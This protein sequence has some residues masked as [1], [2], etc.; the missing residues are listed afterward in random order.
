V[1]YSS[2]LYLLSGSLGATALRE[3]IVLIPAR[4]LA[5]SDQAF[6]LVRRRFA[7]SQVRQHLVLGI[8]A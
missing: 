1:V 3:P 4:P 6:Y 5:R 8:S 7:A 2:Y